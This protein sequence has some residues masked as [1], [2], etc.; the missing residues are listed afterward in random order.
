MLKVIIYLLTT[1]YYTDCHDSEDLKHYVNLFNKESSQAYQEPYSKNAYQ[2]IPKT[3]QYSDYGT[4]DYIVV[5][6]GSAG[7][8]I[9]NRLT[10]NATRNVLLLEAGEHATNF[11]NI[12]GA[13]PYICGLENNWSYKSTSQKTA[14]LGLKNQQGPLHRGKGIGGS[15]MINALLYV[16]GHKRDYD[17][18]YAQ[19]NPGWS[20]NDVLPY[21]KKFE[22]FTSGDSEYRGKEGYLNIMEWKE[23][24]PQSEAFLEANKILGRKEVDYNAKEQLGYARVQLNVRNG[25]RESTG[26]A[27]LVPI[28]NRSNLEI[29][30]GS[31]V[32]KILINKNK[33]AFGVLFTRNG[34]VFVAKSRRDIIISA[35]AIGSPQLLMLSGI[36]PK[37][38]LESLNIRVKQDLPVGEHLEDHS[39]FSYLDFTTNYTEPESGLEEKLQKYLNG[40]GPLTNPLNAHV[41]TFYKSKYE[42]IHDY[43]DVEILMVPSINSNTITHKFWNLGDE[44]TNT[45][46]KDYNPQSTFTL[47]GILFRPKSVGKFRLKS[48]DPFE[49]PLIDPMY[50]SDLNDE[51]ID[52]LYEGIQFMLKLT[53][54]LP[55]Q[56]LDTKLR[57][58][59]LPACQIHNYLSRKYW[60]CFLRQLVCGVFHLIGTCKMGPHPSEGAVVDPELKVFGI[61]NLRVADASIIPSSI[62][63]HTNAPSIMIGEKAADLIKKSN[64]VI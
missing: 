13:M 22:N 24:N 62:S 14:C 3:K 26:N 41:V 9:A 57:H 63:G 11:T 36:G 60:L 53:E 58:A 46:L 8:V 45:I 43:P 16:R 31:Y 64:F 39:F 47:I 17:N 10:E 44:T 34:K 52:I 59:P 1:F 48:A 56:K 42:Q 15:S 27:F 12:P 25:K 7:A 18:W 50:L 32:I 55:F 35:G 23:T 6:A 30:T 61:R 21:F 37:S 29:L 2:Y 28:M 38:H 19:G 33:K 4:F 49:Y 54:T 51:D 20:Y 40:N 5:G